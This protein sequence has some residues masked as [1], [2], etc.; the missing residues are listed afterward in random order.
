M[1]GEPGGAVDLDD[2]WVWEIFIGVGHG[3]DAGGGEILRCE[4]TA[5]LCWGDSFDP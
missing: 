4:E 5:C 1:E 2:S 3:G